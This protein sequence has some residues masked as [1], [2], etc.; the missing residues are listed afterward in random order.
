M[1]IRGFC[2]QERKSIGSLQIMMKMTEQLKLFIIHTIALRLVGCFTSILDFL[3]YFM[4][5]SVIRTHNVDS[6]IND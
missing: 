4:D 2:K 3:V 1:G 5:E 6:T